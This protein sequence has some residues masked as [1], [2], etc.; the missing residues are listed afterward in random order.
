[1]NCRLSFVP[2]NGLFGLDQLLFFFWPPM[3]AERG[4]LI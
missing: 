3:P 2:D 1:M 4:L